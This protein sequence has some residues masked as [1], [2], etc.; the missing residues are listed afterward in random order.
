MMSVMGKRFSRRGASVIIA[1]LL[2]IAIAVAAAVLLYVFSI[3]LMGSLQGGGGQQVKQQ[4][5][6]SAYNWNTL[7][8]PVLTIRNVGTAGVTVGDVF[9]NGVASTWALSVPAGAPAGTTC[10]GT[11][12]GAVPVQTSCILTVSTYG[13]GTFG[14]GTAPTSGVAYPVKIVSI[15]GGVFSYSAIAGQAS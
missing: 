9:V 4:L 14:T 1:A 2:L 3:G 13:A 5:I 8:S 10:G 11:T 6:M 15:D 12:P 7:N